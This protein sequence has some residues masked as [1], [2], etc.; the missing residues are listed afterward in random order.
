MLHRSCDR[1]NVRNN[2]VWDNGDAGIA[3]YESSDSA[4]TLNKLTGNVR[5]YIFFK[6]SQGCPASKAWARGEDLVAGTVYKDSISPITVRSVLFRLLSGERHNYPFIAPR[7]DAYYS[8]WRVTPQTI[9]PPSCVLFSLTPRTILWLMSQRAALLD[10]LSRQRVFVGPTELTA[11]TCTRTRSGMTAT[12]DTRSTCVS[13]LIQRSVEKSLHYKCSLRERRSVWRE[14]ARHARDV[15]TCPLCNR[16]VTSAGY[17]RRETF[18]YLSAFSNRKGVAV[19]CGEDEPKL[20]CLRLRC[21]SFHPHTISSPPTIPAD[22]GS[23]EPLADG[24]E[25]GDILENS[26]HR[27]TV[28]SGRSEAMKIT[29]AHDNSF[30][31]SRKPRSPLPSLF[32]HQIN[33]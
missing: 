3:L 32:S 15:R 23:D 27:N 25:N 28:Y 21:R 1:A 22:R 19:A 14:R 4:V 5:E 13:L 26:F 18:S 33:V 20:T 24:N 6:V 16:H 12:T 31:V 29:Y 30:L 2:E 11:T 17:V 9:P 10:D 7:L 8:I